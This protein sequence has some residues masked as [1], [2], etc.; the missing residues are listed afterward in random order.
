MACLG[1][2]QQVLAGGVISSQN[3]SKANWSS[4]IFNPSRDIMVY[5]HSEMCQRWPLHLCKA[6][7]FQLSLAFHTYS[8][9]EWGLMTASAAALIEINLLTFENPSLRLLE[10]FSQEE[11]THFSCITSLSGR[12][13]CVLSMFSNYCLG[14]SQIC[15]R[16]LPVVTRY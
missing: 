10:C 16:N 12:S 15:H 8:A 6:H 11:K 14:F 9:F 4:G 13:I 7:V 2:M 3:F 1:T 5:H